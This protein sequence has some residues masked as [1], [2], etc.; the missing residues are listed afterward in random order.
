MSRK[1][2]DVFSSG[3]EVTHIYNYGTSSETLLKTVSVREGQPLTGK[4]IY[5]MARNKLPEVECSECNTMA[6]WLNGA[7]G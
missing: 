1:I 2:D 6:G 4:P 5:L 7:N 3:I